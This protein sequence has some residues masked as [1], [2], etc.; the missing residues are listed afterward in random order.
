MKSQI[1]EK[2]ELL[3]VFFLKSGKPQN[4]CVK[5]PQNA[6]K[7]I[8]ISKKNHGGACPPRTPLAHS[9]L[10]RSPKAS[11]LDSTDGH[12]V[13][14]HFRTPPL[15]QNPVSASGH[16]LLIGKVSF[17]IVKTEC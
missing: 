7:G 17:F 4:Y 9:G 14:G 8:D 12:V 3:S 15:F 5:V 16:M 1:N 10:V 11:A 2:N 13:V 6:A